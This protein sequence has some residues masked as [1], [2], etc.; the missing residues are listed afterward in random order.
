MPYEYHLF[1]IVDNKNDERWAFSNKLTQ[2]WNE[3]I[4][5]ID[6]ENNQLRTIDMNTNNMVNIAF[7]YDINFDEYKNADDELVDHKCRNPKSF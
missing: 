5:K 1:L 3:N 4:L 6:Y 7:A 2:K